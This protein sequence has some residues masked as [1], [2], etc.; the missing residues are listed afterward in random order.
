LAGSGIL[1]VIKEFINSAVGCVVSVETQKIMC[2]WGKPRFWNSIVCR[3]ACIGNKV[4]K[5]CRK[6]WLRRMYY[7][8]YFWYKSYV[9]QAKMYY[10]GLM[11]GYS[12]SAVIKEYINSAVGL[13]VVVDT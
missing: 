3:T 11:V 13:V 12:C 5:K 2:A 4:K 9:Q 6:I 8:K 10:K 1:A 7:Y